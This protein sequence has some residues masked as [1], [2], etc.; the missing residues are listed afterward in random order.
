MP[1]DITEQIYIDILDWIGLQ[2][3]VYVNKSR[4]QYRIP[5]SWLGKIPR[6]LIDSFDRDNIWM[7]YEADLRDNK[8]HRPRLHYYTLSRNG[9][10]VMCGPARPKSLPPRSNLFETIVSVKPEVQ[11]FT[12]FDK[13]PT[14]L[15]LLQT[16]KQIR[17]Q[18]G[19]HLWHRQQFEMKIYLTRDVKKAAFCPL[20]DKFLARP[21]ATGSAYDNLQK[22]SLS[23]GIDFYAVPMYT[24]NQCQR[25]VAV[26]QTKML[27]NHILTRMPNLRELTI[28][29]PIDY[30]TLGENF[31]LRYIPLS[32]LSLLLRSSKQ[33]KRLKILHVSVYTP[34]EPGDAG[35]YD[36][37]LEDWSRQSWEHVENWEG[38][39]LTWTKTEYTLRNVSLQSLEKPLERTSLILPRMKEAGLRYD[40]L[41]TLS[42]QNGGLQSNILSLKSLIDLMTGV[43]L[44]SMDADGTKS[45]GPAANIYQM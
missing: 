6:Q 9:K 32:M 10:P 44:T 41:M 5:R 12:N 37:I 11:S 13:Y 7:R 2:L 23:I 40:R 17:A 31:D 8:D 28:D 24:W 14:L 20:L 33:A 1:Y 18:F 42:K 26:S 4:C 21:F 35:L 30:Y 19:E 29:I 43:Q 15:G 34:G 45:D 22:F 36:T 38:E 27:L 3:F 39:E 25:G 16:C